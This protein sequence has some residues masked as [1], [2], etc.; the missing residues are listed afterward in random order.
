MLIFPKKIILNPEK[1]MCC[2]V[3][4]KNYKNLNAQQ[5]GEN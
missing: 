5:K 1:T 2:S 3:I 4:A